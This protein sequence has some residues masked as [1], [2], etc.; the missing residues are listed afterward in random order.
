M[1][2]I[3][4]FIMNSELECPQNFCD[5]SSKYCKEGRQPKWEAYNIMGPA[6]KRRL[7]NSK[8]PESHEGT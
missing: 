4:C 8:W 7:M 5:I 1:E 3:E 2:Q 6:R